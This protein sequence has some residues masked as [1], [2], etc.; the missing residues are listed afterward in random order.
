LYR[1]FGIRHHGPGSALRLREALHQYQPD[2]VLIEGPPEGNPLLETAEMPALKP[3]LAILVYNPK[4]LKQA[5]FYP[6]ARFS[7]EWVAIEHAQ[8]VMVPVRFIDLSVGAR[9]PENPQ[10]DRQDPLQTIAEQA[11]YEDGESWW[12][13]TVEGGTDLED[14]FEALNDLMGRL[15]EKVLPPGGSP[16][17]NLLREAFMR[18]QIRQAIKE[19]YTRI[20]VV[21]G[22]FH[23]P[24]LS[25]LP[26]AKNDNALLRGMK[27]QKMLATWIPWTYQRL[28]FASGYGAG[29]RSP[30][31]YELIYAYPP[32][33]RIEAWMSRV[34]GLF[35]KEGLQS[36]PAHVMEGIK[37]AHNLAAL[38]G[39]QQA[40]L[41]EL[42]DSVPAVFQM[43]DRSALALVHQQ[44]VVGD[45]MGQVP[46]DSPGYPLQK[47]IQQLQKSLRLRPKAERKEI[48][49]DLRKDFD[50]RKSAFL[51]RMGLLGISWA[52]L[53]PVRQ[54]EGTFRESW[55]LKWQ[56]E[57]ELQIIEAAPLGNTVYHASKQKLADKI[58]HNQDLA[59]ATQHL[60]QVLLADFPDLLPEIVSQLRSLSALSTDIEVMMEAVPQ[61]VKVWRYGDVRNTQAELLGTI[62]LSLVPRICIGLPDA[63]RLLEQEYGDQLFGKIQ[64]VQGSIVLLQQSSHLSS[65]SKQWFLTLE[66]LSLQSETY[67]KIAGLGA[68]ILF[69]Q[70]I[71]PAETVAVNM[72]QA[73]SPGTPVREAADWV[74]GLLH[75]SGWLLIHYLP[76]FLLLDQWIG[77]LN[78]D[79][80]QA[81]L[82]LLRRTFAQFSPAERRKMG[83][84]ARREPAKQEARG[85]EIRID[86]DRAKRVL[87][88]LQQILGSTAISHTE[89]EPEGNEGSI[90]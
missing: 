73:L 74:E 31:W 13:A 20:A 86:T 8:E 89:T 26:P 70:G 21:C 60:D 32:S 53:V 2:L 19:G 85:K 50:Q 33:K 41:A 52:R 57:C 65:L 30:A 4:E 1:V 71:W 79:Q 63:C 76:L 37:L 40:G 81:Q 48:H 47:D 9:W 38:R 88:V 11:G 51:H 61:L 55:S 23:G 12:D 42:M 84:M 17:L 83:E 78:E 54:H 6:F 36:S 34:A 43:G 80:F 59:S 16:D 67:A 82:P 7:P 77:S 49:L 29:V 24:A 56:A 72:S 44:L 46:E 68:R 5:S 62:L 69:D 25:D 22:A 75:G 18:K 58:R 45:K 87:P 14:H 66:K 3:P 28:S 90:C 27:R 35:R 39:L 10:S 15:R 64:Q